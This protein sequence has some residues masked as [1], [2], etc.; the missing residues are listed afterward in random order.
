[1]EK[2]LIADTAVPFCAALEKA[3]ENRYEVHTCTTGDETLRLL[4]T[5]K[6]YALILNLRLP[7]M[8]GLE[9][10]RS[11]TYK[12]P[13]VLAMTTHTS[14]YTLQ[15]AQNEG[16]DFIV[17]LP[18]TV[19]S[20]VSHVREMTQMKKKGKGMATPQQIAETHL[21][22]LGIPAHLS[23]FTLLRVGIPLF[24]QDEQQSLNK[25]L[26][27]AIAELCGSSGVKSVERSIRRIIEQAWQN[28]D[29]EVWEKYFP[30]QTEYPTNKEFIAVLAQKVRQSAP[31]K[32]W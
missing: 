23:G 11:S 21:L 9:V 3:F 1:M 30:E 31:D 26:Y 16:V 10:L 7:Y 5:W 12:P 4:E 19:A 8:D 28:R 20:M 29:R 6:P 24:A 14:P 32:I 18:C 27:P 22:R 17:M 2:L 25:E 15:A 13:V